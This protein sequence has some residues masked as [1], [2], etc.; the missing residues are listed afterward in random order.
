M[1]VGIIGLRAAEIE[2]QEDNIRKWITAKLDQFRGS[3]S[4]EPPLDCFCGG[5]KGTDQIFGECVL[6]S[7]NNLHIIFPYERKVTSA[8][9][10][11]SAAA[12]SVSYVASHYQKGCYALQNQN[13]VD[14]I[15]A[16]LVVWTGTEQ[17]SIGRTIKMARN[18]G[19]IIEYYTIGEDSD[20]LEEGS[21]SGVETE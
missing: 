11:L 14:N 4:T 9:K 13:M 3:S 6:A 20:V 1:R 16:L 10:G 18:A 19:R 15:D 12:M 17:G 5:G 8:I 21:S 7:G 2:G